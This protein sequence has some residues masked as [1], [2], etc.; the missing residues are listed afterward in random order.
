MLCPQDAIIMKE[1]EEGFYIPIIDE[2][3][4]I[5]CS[6]CA[7]ECPQNER[8]RFRQNEVLRVLGARYKTDA[9]LSKSAS[10]GVFVG[11][12]KT[13]LEQGES[14]VFGCAF[15]ANIVARHICVTDFNGI[16]P[17]QSSKYVQSDIGDTYY[18]AKALLDSGKIVLFSATPCQIAGLYAFL[19]RDY[20]GLFTIDLV[21][22]GVPSPLLFKRYLDWLGKKY[23]EK[24]ICY[25]FRCKEKIGWGLS[26]KAKTKTKAKVSFAEIDPY[27]SAFLEGNTYCECC[28]CC[29]YANTNRIADLTIGDFWGIEQIHPQFFDKRGVSLCLVNTKK[30]EKLIAK[31]DNF[32]LIDS[33]LANAVLKQENLKAPI[34]RPDSRDTLKKLIRAVDL[35]HAPIFRI[36]PKSRLKSAIKTVFPNS[37]IRFIKILKFIVMKC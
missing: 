33:S 11:I 25:N 27:Y 14:A 6:L 22:H 9:L 32:E 17:L 5:D 1:D 29:K 31:G 34:A 26:Y 19:G 30:G 16:A 8:P 35:F 21:C 4:C 24:I 18:Q 37:V 13:I 20:D 23:H 36:T 15:D 7:K 12:A 3:L 28:Y 10:G 2:S